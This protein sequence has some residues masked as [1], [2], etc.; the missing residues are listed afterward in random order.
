MTE[1]SA[2]VIARIVQ[3]MEA[4]L[5]DYSPDRQTTFDQIETW[6][7]QLQAALASSGAPTNVADGGALNGPSRLGESPDDRIQGAK[8]AASSGAQTTE[9]LPDI[10][11]IEDVASLDYWQRAHR[12]AGHRITAHKLYMECSCGALYRFQK[13]ALAS[14]GAPPQKEEDRDANA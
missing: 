7:H 1:P 12:E 4:I 14:S 10:P 13:L 9:Q 6:R 8:S 2:D 3:E 5:V 11:N